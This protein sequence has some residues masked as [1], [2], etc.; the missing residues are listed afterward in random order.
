VK[1]FQE[2]EEN[3]LMRSSVISTFHHVLY[4]EQVEMDFVGGHVARMAGTV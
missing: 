4:Y 3:Y 1:R 2:A